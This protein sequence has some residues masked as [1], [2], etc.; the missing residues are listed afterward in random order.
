MSDSYE[1]LDPS[2]TLTFRR[3]L[4]PRSQ[5]ARVRGLRGKPYGFPLDI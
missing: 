1:V 2:T 3:G 4:R 5:G